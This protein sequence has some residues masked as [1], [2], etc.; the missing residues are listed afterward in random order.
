LIEYNPSLWAMLPPGA[1]IF[2]ETLE[3][4]RK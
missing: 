3:V 4:Y 2:T 1:E